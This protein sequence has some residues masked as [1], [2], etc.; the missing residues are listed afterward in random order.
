MMRGEGGGLN[1]ATT[2][3]ASR[4]VLTDVHVR[5]LIGSKFAVVPNFEIYVNKQ[6]VQLLDLKAMLTTRI[7][8]IENVGDVKLYR[9][10][11]PK[12]ERTNRLKGIAWWVNAR[13]VGEPSW[14]GLDG[15]GQLP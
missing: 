4:L 7:V 15:A 11:P 13:M 1:H 2:L 9:L 10:D 5:E 14:E 6:R 12:Q 3:T 8:H